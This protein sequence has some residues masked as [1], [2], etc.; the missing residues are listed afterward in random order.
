MTVGKH[1]NQVYA[2]AALQEMKVVEHKETEKLSKTLARA[3][4]GGAS[5]FLIAMYYG[6]CEKATLLA[7]EGGMLTEE[8]GLPNPMECCGDLGGMISEKQVRC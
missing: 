5:A 2:A 6:V 3:R 1:S 7:S 8:S 4:A